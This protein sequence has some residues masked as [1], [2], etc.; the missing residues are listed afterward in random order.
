MPRIFLLIIIFLPFY[1]FAQQ[2]VNLTLFG[3]FSNYSGDLQEKRFT[4]DQSH[5]SFGAG[6]SYEVAPKI[7]VR[8]ALQ[9]GKI[10]A[11]DKRSND[12]MLFERNLNFQSQM[13]EA[14]LLGDYS[15]FDL[16]GPKK[17]TPYV[18]AG[19]ALYRF[20]PYTFDTTGSKVYL[21]N[22]GTEG[23]GLPEYPDRKKYNLIQLSIP[24]GGGIRFRINDN[25]YLG[26]E[27]GLRKT[28]T[29]YMDDVSSTYADQAALLAGN[30]PRAVEMAFRGDE[31]KNNPLPYPGANTVRGGAKFK[32][33]YYF[34]GI[35]LS[36]G[37]LNDT[38]KLF[39]KRE[40][41]GSVDCPPSVL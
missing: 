4:L 6:L 41:K 5:G 39:G 2:K 14:S 18:F 11:D 15:L 13:F 12:I 36:I 10:S 35:T 22:L 20:N 27:I 40:R 25:T 1:V 21:K 29:D 31:L 9:Y 23:Q 16:Q 3:G 30:G 24:F 37:I 19:I 17:I 32:D 26:Y 34:S 28:F 7:L 33:W 38:G 8:G